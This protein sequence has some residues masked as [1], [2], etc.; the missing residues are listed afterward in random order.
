[1]LENDVIYVIGGESPFDIADS[2]LFAL[3]TTP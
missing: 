1:V 3:N 2:G